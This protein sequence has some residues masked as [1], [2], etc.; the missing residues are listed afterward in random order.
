M[1]P[2]LD[3][4]VDRGLTY[5]QKI[6]ALARDAEA[7]LDVLAVP[8]RTRELLASGVICDLFEG[9]APFRPRYIIPDYAAFMR[10]G[11]GFLRIK[12]PKN[13]LEA[14]HALMA[15]YHHVPSITNFP[16]WLGN[17]DALLDPFVAAEPKAAEIIGLFLDHIDR[18]LNDSFCHANIGP[19]DSAA[20]RLILAHQATAGN[21]VPNITLKYDP[22]VT[23]ENF[24]LDAARTALVTAKP[25]FANHPLFAR[26][27]TDAGFADYAIASCYNG[28]PVGGGSLTLVRLNLARLAGT[29]T[30]ADDLFGRALPEAVRAM[31]GLMDARIDFLVTRSG[32]FESSFLV[33]EK[34]ISFDR[35]TAMFGL[36]GLAEC[37]NRHFAGTDPAMRFGHADA[38][39]AFGLRIIAEIDRLVREHTNPH[40]TAFGG[41]FQLHAQVGIDSDTG[42]SPGCRIPIGEEPEILEHLARSAPFHKYFPSGIGD[43]FAFEPTVKN[44]PLQI[45]DIVRGAFSLGARYLSCYAADADVVRITGYLVKRSEV[46][47]LN[48]GEAVLQDTTVLGRNAINNLRVLDR[49]L[50]S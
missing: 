30:G 5:Q 14:T 7:T 47:R 8:E 11:S 31:L 32:F 16:V 28:L 3:T 20:A 49:R 29:A 46:A 12:P 42:V 37:V 27:F 4:L 45:V 33:N 10:E 50:R 25:S 41:R 39:D 6:H 21:A 18:T 22:A 19:A 48:Q 38:A 36:V 1:H 17:I 9:N 34:L 40:L 15:L 24:L 13:L 43:V 2:I 44:N 26:E 35:F 23:P